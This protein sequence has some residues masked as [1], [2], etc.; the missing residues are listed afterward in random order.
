MPGGDLYGE[1][2]PEDF[3]VLIGQALAAQQPEFV[4]AFP[5][6]KFGPGRPRGQPNKQLSTLVTPSALRQRRRRQKKKRDKYSG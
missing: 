2:I 6:L 3:W 1:D 4:T 5:S